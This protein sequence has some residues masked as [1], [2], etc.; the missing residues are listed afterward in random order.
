[1]SNSYIILVNNGGEYE[2]MSFLRIFSEKELGGIK[3][4][5]GSYRGNFDDGFAHL[6]LSEEK[7]YVVKP[8][9]IS[10]K[11]YDILHRISME[12]FE[13]I[14]KVDVR[15][16]KIVANGKT[17]NFEPA[18]KADFVINRINKILENQ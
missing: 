8:N 3:H 4:M 1:M 18:M 10:D 12:N 17:H 16:L 11:P 6:V 15:K 5:K 14:K 7:L 13:E 2:K 9:S